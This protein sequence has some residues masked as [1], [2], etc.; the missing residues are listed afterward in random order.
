M[1]ERDTV[2]RRREWRVLVSSRKGDDDDDDACRRDCN[3]NDVDTVDS[4]DK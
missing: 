3:A 4:D 2:W 1:N